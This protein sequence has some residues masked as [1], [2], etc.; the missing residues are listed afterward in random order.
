MLR[1]PYVL[2]VTAD[3]RRFAAGSSLDQR[4]HPAELSTD[5]HRRSPRQRAD[6]GSSSGVGFTTGPA[7]LR[8]RRADPDT[9]G[10]DAHVGPP[11][12]ER[13]MRPLCRADGCEM[14]G[15]RL[16]ASESRSAPRFRRVERLG[17][18]LLRCAPSLRARGV[19]P[20]LRRSSRALSPLI[21]STSDDRATQPFLR[22]G[23]RSRG[24]RR[25]RARRPSRESLTAGPRRRPRI[26]AGAPDSV[27]GAPLWTVFAVSP[28][29]SRPRSPGGLVGPRRAAELVPVSL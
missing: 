16:G 11:A 28:R 27:S 1:P 29:P 8:R 7:P 20:A 2:S 9:P 21:G 23:R 19:S 18:L 4:R 14:G 3:S 13:R 17:P 5:A 24:G 15:V 6:G 12:E 25:R 10:R 26:E 22:R